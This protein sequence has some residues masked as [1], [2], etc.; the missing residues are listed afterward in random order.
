MKKLRGYHLGLLLVA[1][2]MVSSFHT[3]TR[4]LNDGKIRTLVIDAG[5]GGKD[6]GA[7]GLVSK[8]KEHTLAIATEL[9][10]VLNEKL[11]DLKVVMTR[12]DDTFIELANRA[13]EVANAEADFFISIHC[14]SNP[15][16][17]AC[18]AETYVLG[19]HKA[20][21][22]MDVVMRENSVI[23]MEDNFEEVY[24]GFDPNSVPAYIF[25]KYVTNVHLEMSNKMAL[26]VQEQ[27][28]TRVGR[29]DRGVKQAGYLVLWRAS[30]PAILIETGFISNKEEEL[31]L[32]S[33]NGRG[34]MASAIYRAVRDYN[35]EITG[36]GGE[37][38]K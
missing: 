36:M 29:K 21:A 7:L 3:P 19:T 23:M 31:F 4:P 34:Y 16:K 24:E 2:L 18:G 6:P 27:F 20:E 11:P 15:N 12:S 22:N 32:N 14:N 33:E 30:K 17:E 9:K 37:G 38:G 5:H 10:K 35:A 1:G 26:K 8:E 28:A 13:K 25:F